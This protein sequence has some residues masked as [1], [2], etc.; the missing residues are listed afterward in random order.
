VQ[1]LYQE[2]KAEKPWVK[3][4]ISPFGIWRPGV[5]APIRGFDAYAK[6]YADSRLW[7]AEGWLD[8]FTPQLYWSINAPEQSFP[9]LLRWWADQNGK[10]RHLWPG[11]SVAGVDGRRT[12]S[13]VLNQVRLTR[14]QSGATGHIFWSAKPLLLNRNGVADS[15]GRDVYAQP[16]LVPASPWLDDALP[17][18]P[19]L[20]AARTFRSTG[21]KL[22]WA[23]ETSPE[24]V[25]LWVLQTKN[26]GQWRNEVLPG[27]TKSYVLSQRVGPEAIAVTAVGRCGKAGA[28]AVLE[29]K[30]GETARA[31]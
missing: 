19:K 15:L 22:T 1:R 13:E 21:W 27:N 23:A 8:Y 12:A 3:F 28:P 11:I 31:E 16:A 6:L 25:W 20:K 29:K 14:Q 9:V 24:Q 2:I 30:Q 7:L 5:P 4:G 26:G 17:P 18:T 10:G